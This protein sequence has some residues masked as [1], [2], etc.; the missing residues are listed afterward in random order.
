VTKTTTTTTTT[1]TTKIIISGR[2]RV[3]IVFI[4]L[5]VIRNKNHVSKY[6]CMY[7]DILNIPLVVSVI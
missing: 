2:T 7:N 1:T 4:S 3:H 6:V 5:V